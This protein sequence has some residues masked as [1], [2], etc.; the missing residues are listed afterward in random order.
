MFARDFIKKVFDIDTCDRLIQFPLM[1]SNPEVEYDKFESKFLIT[2]EMINYSETEQDLSRQ[3]GFY[4]E[5]ELTE[6]LAR[7]LIREIIAYFGAI[8]SDYNPNTERVDWAKEGF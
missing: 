2:A 7:E 8:S 5:L 4:N 6:L 1:P 3:H